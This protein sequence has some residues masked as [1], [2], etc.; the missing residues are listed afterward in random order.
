MNETEYDELSKYLESKK[1]QGLLRGQF[2]HG[3]SVTSASW[4]ASGRRIV[5][6]S[7]DDA[8]RGTPSARLPHILH[9][10]NGFLSVG[11][12]AGFAGP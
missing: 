10:L 11:R 8:I 4:D 6:T 9:I 2:P 3:Y 7:Y 12:E 5:S 1:G